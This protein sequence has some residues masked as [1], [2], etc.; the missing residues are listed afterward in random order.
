MKEKALSFPI[1]LL[2]SILLISNF[3][4]L[5]QDYA[6]ITFYL[7]DN[8]KIDTFHISGFWNLTNIYIDDLAS[9]PG[10]HNWTWVQSQEWFGGGIG[11]WSNPYRIE[12]ITTTSISIR[13]SNKPFIL[14][15]CTVFNSTDTAIYFSHV[16]NG[17][18]I[19]NMCGFNEY[20]IIL[21]EC[22]NNTIS[23]NNI[24]SSKTYGLQIF[25]SFNNT[26]FNNR[27]NKCGIS[28]SYSSIQNESNIIDTSNLINGKPFYFYFNEKNLG[29][30]NF[31][32]AGQVILHNCNDSLISDLNLNQCSIG[33][34]L[35]NCHNNWVENN[36]LTNNL[37]VG[38]GITS[39]TNNIIMNNTF[40]NNSILGIIPSRGIDIT[41]STNNIIKNN[42]FNENIIGISIGFSE[43]GIESN[44]NQIYRNNISNGL[45]G[46]LI[47][48]GEKNN[49]S[50]NDIVNNYYAI[51]GNCDDILILNNSISHNKVGLGFIYSNFNNF[52]NNSI[53]NNEFGVHLIASQENRF[54]QNILANNTKTGIY[55]EQSD[56]ND[57]TE[58]II[59]NNEYGIK[60]NGSSYNQIGYNEVYNNKVGIYLDQS[61]F[62]PHGPPIIRKCEYNTIFSNQI[63]FNKDN[64][65]YMKEGQWNNISNNNINNNNK[66]GI[67]LE[68]SNVNFILENVINFN[69]CGINLT[70][71]NSN[72]VISN[73]LYKNNICIFED[74]SCIGNDFEDNNCFDV[75][76]GQWIFYLIIG[77]ILSIVGLALIVFVI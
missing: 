38:I 65:I 18:I 44:S 28:I 70:A 22:S 49:I 25:N 40:T 62:D 21:L 43:Y 77:C 50:K 54:S 7:D 30:D 8:E 31:T 68:D 26:I 72:Q 13:Y 10:A 63:N 67:L 15:N 27:L 37:I 16:S 45:C 35:I 20:G 74:N 23:D 58:N 5:N 19:E 41:S 36:I 46:L 29:H 51:Y 59:N 52:S 3:I 1:L 2:F 60:L 73:S 66:N 55:L 61:Y 14:R 71:S 53:I 64:G 75:S 47:Y 34:S 32:N 56:I 4:K 76:N 39:S 11:S 69:Y 6:F 42:I 48:G 24:I 9:G 33:I 12:N 57:I 17:K